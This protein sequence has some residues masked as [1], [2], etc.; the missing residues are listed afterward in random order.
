MSSRDGEY[1]KQ[2]VDIGHRLTERGMVGTNEGNIS[3]CDRDTGT[4]YITPSGQSKEFLTEEMIIAVDMEGNYLDRMEGLK[5]SSETVMHTKMYQLRP[6]VNG[7]VHCHAPFCSA[8]AISGQPIRTKAI[9]EVNIMFGGEIPLLPYGEPGTVH[10]IDG[11][12]RHMGSDVVLLEN[13]GMLAMGAN[14]QA[15]YGRTVTVEMIA[16]TVWLARVMGGETD[17]PEDKLAQLGTWMAKQQ[18]R[19]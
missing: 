1:R 4:V 12:M 7:V 13:H 16:K 17:I 10:L 14:L 18:A 8:F 15:A 2:I 9:A 3:I 5:S 6:D 11:Y 19:A